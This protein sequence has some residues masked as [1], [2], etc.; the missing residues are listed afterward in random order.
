MHER[1]IITAP[2]HAIN[3]EFWRVIKEKSRHIR[4]LCTHNSLCT[5]TYKQR[6]W[7]LHVRLILPQLRG[8]VIQC[9]GPRPHLQKANHIISKALVKKFDAGF[10]YHNTYMRIRTRCKYVEFIP[11]LRETSMAWCQ[12][13]S[14][15]IVRF[16]CTAYMFYVEPLN[17]QL[18]F[19]KWVTSSRVF[20][21]KSI[22]IYPV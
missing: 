19:N 4:N 15:N 22:A 8:T 1:V 7:P 18:F 9:I 14:I 20:R 11:I 16:V 13:Q 5:K 10:P 21:Q 17:R 12:L 2:K 3:R 6:R